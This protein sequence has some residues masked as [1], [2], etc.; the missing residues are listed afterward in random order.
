MNSSGSLENIKS[1]PIP[2]YTLGIAL[3]VLSLIYLIIGI[4]CSTRM[5][6]IFRYKNNETFLA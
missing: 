1:A 2:N 3:F 6:R 5:C 4:Y